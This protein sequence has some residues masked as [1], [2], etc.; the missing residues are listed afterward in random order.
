MLRPGGHII[1]VSSESVGMMFPYLTMYQATKSALER[2]SEGLHHELQPNGIRVTTVRAGQMYGENFSINFGP[3]IGMRF[4]QAC[5][6]AGLNLRERP[7]SD[8]KSVSDVFRAVIDLPEDV[9]IQHV[10]LSARR[11]RQ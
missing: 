9:H 10:S 5:L 2:F 8:F 6:A 11:G 3:E 7:L 4:H 1:N